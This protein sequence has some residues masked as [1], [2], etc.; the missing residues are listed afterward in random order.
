MKYEV[1]FAR[2]CKMIIEADSI[3]DAEEKSNMIDDDEIEKNSEPS[4]TPYGYIPWNINE[5]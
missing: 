2:F 3:K 1:E 5:V 4:T